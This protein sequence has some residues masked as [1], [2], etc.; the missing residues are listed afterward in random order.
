MFPTS[1]RL[2]LRSKL[3]GDFIPDKI[4]VM[5]SALPPTALYQTTKSDQ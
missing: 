2:F 1:L 5:E 3:V 4:A